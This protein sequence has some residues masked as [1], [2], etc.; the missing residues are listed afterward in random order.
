M[1]YLPAGHSEHELGKGALENLENL[2]TMQSTQTMPSKYSPELHV[3]VGTDVGRSVGGVVGM[4]EGSDV[5]VGT[6]VGLE[7]TGVGKTEGV[8]VGEYVGTELGV[9]VG[10]SVGS[11]LGVFVGKSVGDV[12][13][14]V[15]VGDGEGLQ[16]AAGL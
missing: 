3:T 8:F 16:N 7:G 6:C 4:L 10:K 1:L 9:F 5:T 14:G 15:A 2:P 13:E 12:V 11:E